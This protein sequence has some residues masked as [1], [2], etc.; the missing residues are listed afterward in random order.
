MTDAGTGGSN[1]AG[2]QGQQGT[3]NG[4]G[5]AGHADAGQKAGAPDIQKA[6]D[7]VVARERTRAERERTELLQRIEQLEASQK[8]KP[9]ED[10]AAYREK[11][12]AAR[13]PVL[14]ELA[15]ERKARE[16]IESRIATAEI[17]SAASDS[18]DPDLVAQLIKPFVKVTAGE[19]EVVDADGKPRY[20]AT[21]PMRLAELVAETLAAK[22]YLA[23]AQM[24]QGAG[25]EG[26]RNAATGDVKQQI[27][28]LEKHGIGT[29]QWHQAQSL[30]AQHVAA[31]MGGK[32]A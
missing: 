9:A 27:A 6:I 24:R 19:I 20:G 21:G 1:D 2:Q 29:P 14:D 5:N 30:K 3:P 13:K 4:A 16:A 10:D 7:A 25:F 17:K 11:I 8:P 12:E 23:K 26:S 15:A 32:A 22:P 31:L 28:E 18:V